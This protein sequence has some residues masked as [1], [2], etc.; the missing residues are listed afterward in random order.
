MAYIQDGTAASGAAVDTTSHALKIAPSTTDSETGTVRIK[1]ENDPGGSSKAAYLLSPETSDDYRIRVG[2]DQFLDN[3]VFCYANQN[4]GKH[5]YTST[6]LTFDLNG[7][8][9]RSNGSGITTIN[10][11]A[12][13]QTQAWFPLWG[14]QTSLYAEFVGGFDVAVA[15]NTTVQFGI[16]QPQAT[17]F[18]PKDGVYFECVAGTWNGV[19]FNAGGTQT[20][21]LTDGNGTAFTITAGVNYQ[22][23]ISVT[24]REVKFWINDVLYGK[25]DLATT[26]FAMIQAGTAPVCIRHAIGGVAAGT[27]CRFRL[28]SYSVQGGDAV[29]NRSPGA[30]ATGMG[31]GM[32]IQQGA[33]AGGQ[34]T[35]YALGAAPGAVTL[36]AS[37]APATNTL[38][39]LALLPAA[40][41]AAESD[42]P[43]FAWQNPAG[44]SAIPGKKFYCTGVIVGD[45]VIYPTALTGGPLIIQWAIGWGS[46]AASLA[47]TES[48]T[49]ASGTTKIARKHPLGTQVFA[50]AAAAGVLAAGFQR[51][52]S[53]APLCINPG[54]FLHIIIR[55]QGTN[56]TAGTPRVQVT[57]IG[58]FE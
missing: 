31:N 6:T 2:L 49:F 34:L 24:Q 30:R 55:C 52:F 46:T 28:L 17:P 57:P 47:T 1:S 41:T 53:A 21:A 51:D 54:E 44:T 20:V 37:T 50:A 25:I 32:Q 9:L 27:V 39:G 29:D 14:Q 13:F 18:T 26:S 40:I 23:L 36:T 38:G 19:T 8:Y 5:T 15:T 43:L 42:Y 58:Y 16:F 56:T 33:V 11:A 3:E 4:T 35:T 48:T 7:G 12:I 45:A 10:T 22:F